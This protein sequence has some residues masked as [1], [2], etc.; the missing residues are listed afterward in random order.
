MMISLK[1]TPLSI[2]LNLVLGMTLMYACDLDESGPSQ[3]E[4]PSPCDQLDNDSPEA[5]CAKFGP[6]AVSQEECDASDSCQI[7]TF[8]LGCGDVTTAHCSSEPMLV[9]AEDVMGDPAQLCS[10]EGLVLATTE[11]CSADTTCRTVTTPGPCGDLIETLCRPDE[12]DEEGYPDPRSICQEAGLVLATEEEC[13]SGV[14]CQ[15]LEFEVGCGEIAIALCA[16][17][18]ECQETGRVEPEVICDAEVNCSDDEVQSRIACEEYELDRRRMPR[19][20]DLWFDHFLSTSRILSRDL[21][22]W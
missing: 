2:V 1:S 3:I 20:L 14:E 13:S 19:R 12:C 17:D 10:G 18:D 7:Y 4:S 21:E 9:C 22:L 11:E 16:V 5:L 6:V 8:D 15:T